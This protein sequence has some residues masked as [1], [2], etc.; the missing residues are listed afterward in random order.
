MRGWLTRLLR[1]PDP[2]TKCLS[3]HLYVEASLQPPLEPI[4][5]KGHHAGASRRSENRDRLRARPLGGRGYVAMEMTDG[6]RRLVL[7]TDQGGV[8]PDCEPA[9]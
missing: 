3:L 8:R 1:V 2:P 6:V 7:E 4:G 5:H 9:R